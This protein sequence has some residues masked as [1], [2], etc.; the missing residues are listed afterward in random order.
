MNGYA[1]RCQL[2]NYENLIAGV[3]GYTWMY[4]IRQAIGVRQARLIKE[5]ACACGAKYMQ[6]SVRVVHI[7]TG[8]WFINIG[9][10]NKEA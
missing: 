10:H 9:V 8:W 2:Q 1:P 4:M 3:V 6:N 5:M 7:K